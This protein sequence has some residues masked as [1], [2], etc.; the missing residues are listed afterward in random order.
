MIFESQA[1]EEM[2]GDGDDDGFSDVAT[3]GTEVGE[4]SPT[5]PPVDDGGGG[6]GGGGGG[7]GDGDDDDGGGGGGD[8]GDG[9]GSGEWDS[10]RN[11]PGSPTLD[12]L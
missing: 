6:G 2:G 8:G 12:V 7:V 5:F 11:S 1:E 10:G 3:Q 9:G 4:L